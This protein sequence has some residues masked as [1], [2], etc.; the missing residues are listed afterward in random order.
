MPTIQVEVYN[1]D[2]NADEALLLPRNL[3]VHSS[4]KITRYNNNN[5]NNNIIISHHVF[6]ILFIPRNFMQSIN[7]TISNYTYP[8]L[9]FW[10]TSPPTSLGSPHYIDQ[11]I[12]I[13]YSLKDFLIAYEKRS[14][15]KLEEITKN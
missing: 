11:N 10:P 13:N 12:N 2:E 8:F 1:K 5:N 6:R 9:H 14:D 4:N 15:K 7:Y 3:G